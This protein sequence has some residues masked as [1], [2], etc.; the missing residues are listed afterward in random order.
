MPDDRGNVATI[1]APGYTRGT[2]MVRLRTASFML[3]TPPGEAGERIERGEWPLPV[4]VSGE[5]YYPAAWVRGW[6]ETGRWPS[7]VSLV[8]QA[9][10]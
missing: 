2:V 10:R 4:V 1:V 6:I 5:P 8:P 7:E 9:A 3:G